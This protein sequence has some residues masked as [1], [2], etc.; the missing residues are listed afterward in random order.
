MASGTPKN[1]EKETVERLT[2]L[3]TIEKVIEGETITDFEVEI[4][5]WD[6]R[7]LEH[8]TRLETETREREQR[9]EKQKIKIKSWELYRECKTFLENNE[10]NWEHKRQEREIEN[11]RIERLN[12]AKVQ[13]ENLRLKIKQKKLEQD[14]KEKLE[15]L[16]TE[17]KIEL[18]TEEEREYRKDISETKKNL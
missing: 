7:L 15:K 16:P 6:K 10:K 2:N 1:K 4:V 12:R 17:K 13:Q 9:L 5:D 3:R 18:I 8:R 11:K 14:L